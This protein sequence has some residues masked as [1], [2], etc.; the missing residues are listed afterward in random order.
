MILIFS[1]F[2]CLLWMKYTKAFHKMR[3]DEEEKLKELIKRT[4]L[5]VES[6][7]LGKYTYIAIINLLS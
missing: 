5:V 3:L 7:N 6:S 4:Q 1:V 2:A